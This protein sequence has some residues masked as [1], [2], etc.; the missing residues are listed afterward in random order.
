[1][2]MSERAATRVA[3]LARAGAACDRLGAAL[4]EAGA[5][6]ALVADPLSA[7]PQDILAA[8]PQAILV[9]LEPAV[10]EALARFDA[11]L[12]DPAIVVIFD[13]AELAAQRSGWDAARWVRHL[14][15]KLNRHDDV[16]PPGAEEEG[17]WQPSPGPLPP[18]RDAEAYEIAAIADEAQEHAIEVPRDNG[19][20]AAAYLEDGLSDDTSNDIG[21]GLTLATIDDDEVDGGLVDLDSVA[22]SPAGADGFDIEGF[23]VDGFDGDDPA[24]ADGDVKDHGLSLELAGDAAGSPETMALDPAGSTL[25]LVDAD[26]LFA[27]IAGQDAVIDVPATAAPVIDLDALEQRVSA[28]SLADVDSY[29]HGPTRGAVLVEGGLGGPDAVRQL[30]AGIPEGFPRPVLIRLHLDGGRYDRLVKQME[31]AARLP[32]ALAEIG[33]PAD[34]GTVYFVPPGVSLARERAQWMFVDEI[35]VAPILTALPASDSAVLMLSGSSVA[36]VDAVMAQAAA[37]MLVAGQALE[38]CY[39]ASASMA[40]SARGAALGTPAEL[41]E[42]LAE[43][44][45]S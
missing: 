14:S 28:L 23:N 31:R 7:D 45:P 19:P 30:L 41:A 4:L 2:A 32:V 43:R 34:A 33:Q 10:E 17:N 35:G 16:L 38:N 11:V 3:L 21:S 36:D 39:D 29:G 13:E 5:Q 44:W 8:Q 9:A 27:T 12:S 6:V 18:A 22:I 1:M 40:L 37:G 20:V 24:V 15:A 26:A 25:E 42:Q